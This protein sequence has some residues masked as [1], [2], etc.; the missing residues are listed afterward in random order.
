MPGLPIRGRLIPAASDGTWQYQRPLPGGARD[1][2]R[3]RPTLVA[4]VFI[5]HSAD[6]QVAGRPI[7][8]LGNELRVARVAI[9]RGGEMTGQQTGVFALH[10]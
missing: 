8:S 2:H 6:A 5:L 1:D 9:T 4:P 3:G 7:A 10:Q